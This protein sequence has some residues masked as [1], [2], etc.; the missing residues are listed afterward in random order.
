MQVRAFFEDA[1]GGNYGDVPT[2]CFEV[3]TRTKNATANCTTMAKS[4]LR[5]FDVSAMVV[6]GSSNDSTAFKWIRRKEAAA[7]KA[8]V[9]VEEDLVEDC[10]ATLE[11]MYE[12]SK[13]HRATRPM[14]LC[15]NC[16]AGSITFITDRAIT[17]IIPCAIHDGID[18]N[19]ALQTIG[20]LCHFYR[21]L[22]MPVDK[23]GERYALML[24]HSNDLERLLS[25]APLSDTAF[26]NMSREG[27]NGH[28]AE[29]AMY[30]EKRDMID[31]PSLVHSG[32]IGHRSS[33]MLTPIRQHCSFGTNEEL[34]KHVGKN[35]VPNFSEYYSYAGPMQPLGGSS[36]PRKAVTRDINEE[37]AEEVMLEDDPYG[38]AFAQTEEVLYAIQDKYRG[39][40]II[41][42]V[43]LC[44][45]RCTESLKCCPNENPVSIL[46][47]KS[48]ASKRARPRSVL[49]S[50]DSGLGSNAPTTIEILLLFP[51][52]PCRC[53]RAPWTKRWSVSSSCR[54]ASRSSR[55]HSPLL[56][57]AAALARSCRESGRRGSGG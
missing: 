42:E 48:T 30:L 40:K 7:D 16:G 25:Y 17:H 19:E 5:F 50:N 6:T 52:A 49:G 55:G 46:W 26:A 56:A 45:L 44:A 13:E 37:I 34:E 27:G 4:V 51:C 10:Y 38:M 33:N 35:V 8:V 31:M 24:G 47:T 15:T 11:E 54:L 36:G 53:S 57:S 18:L 43:G 14:Y 1:F 21:H 28:F 41:T 12:A 32:R 2:F 39:V 3:S 20:R 9:D 29:G 22:L 23:N